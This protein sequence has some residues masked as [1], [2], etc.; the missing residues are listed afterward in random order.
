MGE[1]GD[2]LRQNL[3]FMGALAFIVAFA[4]IVA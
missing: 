3:L 4:A 1:K 2:W